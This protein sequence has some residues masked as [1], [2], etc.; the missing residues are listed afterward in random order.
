MTI[1]AALGERIAGVP[2]WLLVLVLGGGLYWWARKANSS[3][4]LPGLSAPEVSSAAPCAECGTPAAPMGP[5]LQPNPAAT[6]NIQPAVAS[7][8]SGSIYV[9]T[10]APTFNG[11]DIPTVRGYTGLPRATRYDYARGGPA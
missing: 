10:P 7:L 11:G 1:A 4:I 5:A 8:P 3:A 6:A 9:P 2:A